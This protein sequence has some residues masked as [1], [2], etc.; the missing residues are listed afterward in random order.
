MSRRSV[1][2]RCVLAGLIMVL[3]LGIP[4]ASAKDGEEVTVYSSREP[5][6]I[7]PLLRVFE[8]LTGIRLKLVYVKDDLVGR[9]AGE[10]E[11]T[12]A[13][14]ILANEFKQLISAKAQDLTQPVTLAALTASIPPEDRDVDDHWFA[15]SRRARVVFVSKERVKQPSFTYEELAEPKWKGRICT[16][17][18]LH[19]YNI[20]L[21]ASLIVHKGEAWTEQWLRGLKSNLMAKPAGGDRDQ[22]VNVHAGKCDIALANTYYL[23]SMLSKDS[24]PVQKAAAA[25]VKLIFPNA[26]DRGTHVSISGMALSKHARNPDSATLLMDFLVSEPAQAIYAMDNHEYPVRADVTPSGVV[27]GWGSLKSDFVPLSSLAQAGKKATALIEKV[28]FDLGPG[29]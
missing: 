14:L 18:G 19:P 27:A 26:A 21:V 12:Q 17:S 7:E 24:P 22:I 2:A 6:Y 28:Q 15:L 1:A 16:R 5:E 29:S 13:D 23:G 3:A 9:L 11:R 4:A 10:G 20:G 8:E 25:S